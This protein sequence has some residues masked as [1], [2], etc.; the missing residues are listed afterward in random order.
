MA[1]VNQQD[2]HL[3][4]DRY[5]ASERAIS[6]GRNRRQKTFRQVQNDVKTA[7]PGLTILQVLWWA[8]YLWRLLRKDR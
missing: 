1:A 5:V 4:A 6:R 2:I 8:L 7:F 3:W